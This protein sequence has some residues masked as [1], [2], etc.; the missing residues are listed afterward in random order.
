[1]EPMKAVKASKLGRRALLLTGIAVVSAGSVAGVSFALTSA[2]TTAQPATSHAAATTSQ[3]S[4]AAK[5]SISRPAARALQVLRRTVTAQVKIDTKDGYVTFEFDRGVVTS[6]SSSSVTVLRPDG[7]SVTEGLTSSTHMPKAGTPK[8]GQ[9]VA[10]ISV[11]G[12][13]RYVVDVG[14]F[15]QKPSAGH[16][17]SGS[18]STSGST[19]SIT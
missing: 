19:A 8:T 3:S 9:N 5:S 13:A 17:T 12:N 14:A 2:T 16:S 15:G 11:A 1:M 4:S 6:I 7:Q 18:A 10:V